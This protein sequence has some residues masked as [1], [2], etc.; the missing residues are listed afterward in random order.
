MTRP[1]PVEALLF[2]LDG[3]LVDSMHL[4]FRAYWQE[5]DARGIALDRERFDAAVGG[6][7]SET[8]PALVDR[9][10]SAA[11]VEG[12]HDGKMRR[13]VDNLATEAIPVLPT[14]ALLGA[15]DLRVGLVTSGSWETVR[16]VLDRL[17]WLDVFDAVVTA[18]DVTRGKPDP[19]PY[20]LALARLGV[21]ASHSVA[22]E[23]S[24]PGVEAARGAGIPTIDVRAVR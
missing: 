12:I 23:D 19:E 15:N 18:D 20:E 4:H 14:A 1:P 9:E 5:L 8:I 16:V 21:D 2:D 3:T 24:D 13:F 6:R 7:Y 17:D 10:L 11:E 22:F